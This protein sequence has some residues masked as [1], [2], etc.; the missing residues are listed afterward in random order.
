[1]LHSVWEIFHSDSSHWRWDGRWYSKIDSAIRSF[2]PLRSTQLLLGRG[3][4]SYD[5]TWQCSGQFKTTTN[6]ETSTNYKGC[7]SDHQ[8]TRAT[9]FCGLT[10]CVSSKILKKIYSKSWP[11]CMKFTR[12]PMLQL[13]LQARKDVMMDSCNYAVSSRI[14]RSLWILMLSVFLT[15]CGTEALIGFSSSHSNQFGHL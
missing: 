10:R 9:I 2:L 13:L 1:M 14:T 5:K 12:M 7:H 11:Q 15:D 6:L 3:P 4:V 8:K